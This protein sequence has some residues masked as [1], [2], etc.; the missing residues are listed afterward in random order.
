MSRVLVFFLLFG[1]HLWFGLM[2]EA[3]HACFLALRHSVLGVLEEPSSCPCARWVYISVRWQTL[4]WQFV[5]VPSE[6][7][8]AYTSV[9]GLFQ[10]SRCE[11]EQPPERAGSFLAVALSD[12]FFFVLPSCRAHQH[13]PCRLKTSSKC[14]V[15]TED[16]LQEGCARFVC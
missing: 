5:D 10:V 4:V 14:N 9:S 3:V 11:T 6:T 13:S 7:A 12:H 2:C 1:F 16:K 8:S 15:R